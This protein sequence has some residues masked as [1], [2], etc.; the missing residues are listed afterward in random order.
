MTNSKREY[1]LSLYDKQTLGKVWDELLQIEKGCNHEW[2]YS[3]NKEKRICSYCCLKER[4]RSLGEDGY[5]RSGWIAPPEESD[6][7][8]L[9]KVFEKWEK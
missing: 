9:R 7:H 3:P 4:S 6:R 8:D 1:V 5:F 2:I